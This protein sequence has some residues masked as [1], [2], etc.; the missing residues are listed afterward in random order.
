MGALSSHLHSVGSQSPQSP[1]WRTG[2]ALPSPSHLHAF[3]F[4]QSVAGN[5]HSLSPSRELKV[6]KAGW[7][8]KDVCGSS[9]PTVVRLQAWDSPPASCKAGFLLDL[10]SSKTIKAYYYGVLESEVLFPGGPTPP[11]QIFFVPWG[12]CR[13][14][15]A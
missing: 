15:P 1:A 5:R 8:R 4:G 6:C 9:L 10:S 14:M 13:L 3:S 7:F 2:T 12:E 11:L